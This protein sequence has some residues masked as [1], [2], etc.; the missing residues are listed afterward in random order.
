MALGSLV[1]TTDLV[2]PRLEVPLLRGLAPARG[3]AAQPQEGVLPP[4]PLGVRGEA[5]RAQRGPGQGPGQPQQRQVVLVVGEVGMH[6]HLHQPRYYLVKVLHLSHQCTMI[7]QYSTPRSLTSSTSIS[8]VS[9]S[10]SSPRSQS[11]NT[12]VHRPPPSA[13]TSLLLT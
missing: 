3:H 12:T 1:L 9:E 6:H 2:Q 5:Q 13:A 11:P 10:P 4:L 7:S 8:R